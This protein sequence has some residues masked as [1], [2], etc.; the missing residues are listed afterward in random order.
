MAE[1][2]DRIEEGTMKVEHK[3]SENYSVEIEKND[4]FGCAVGKPTTK[5]QVSLYDL[6]NYHCPGHRTW[7]LDSR[8]ELR[9]VRDAIDSF[10]SLSAEENSKEN[11][12]ISMR[13]SCILSGLGRSYAHRNL[14]AILDRLYDEAKENGYPVCDEWY[15]DKFAVTLLDFQE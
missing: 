3:I 7:Y 2:N 8:D 5:Y 1:T 10:L 9:H 14:D 12:V 15:K 13:P 4:Q 6:M 11:I